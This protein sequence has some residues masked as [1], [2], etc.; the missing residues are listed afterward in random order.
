M[1]S[2]VGVQAVNA[3]LP[4]ILR[5]ALCERPEN[6]WGIFTDGACSKKNGTIGIGLV[7]EDPQG[8]NVAEWSTRPDWWNALALH[9]VSRAP[10]GP[11]TSN[12]AELFGLYLALH[13]VHQVA[14]DQV[15]APSDFEGA[16]D[17]HIVTDSS[18]ALGV[19]TGAFAASSNQW[20]IEPIRKLL[21][22]AREAGARISFG[23]VRG[24]QGHPANERCDILASEARDSSGK[25]PQGHPW[26]AWKLTEQTTIATMIQFWNGALET[27]RGCTSWRAVLDAIRTQYLPSHGTQASSATLH[28]YNRACEEIWLRYDGVLNATKHVAGDVEFLAFVGPGDVMVAV[29][30]PVLGSV[31][32]AMFMLRYRLDAIPAARGLLTALRSWTAAAYEGN[33]DVGLVLAGVTP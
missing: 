20:L 33:E 22:S 31:M 14:W 15:E 5:E 24:H 2:E 17:F 27:L 3:K 25:S 28:T 19:T 16:W 26:L 21:K 11:L 13:I 1:D 4:Q 29:E 10:S 9:D 7:V 18:Y 32:P 12:H 6:S 8:Y 30:Y 23:H